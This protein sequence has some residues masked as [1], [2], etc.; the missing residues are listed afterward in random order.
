MKPPGVTSAQARLRCFL[1]QLASLAQALFFALG[2]GS[3]VAQATWPQPRVAYDMHSARINQIRATPDGTRVLSVSEDKTVRVWRLSDLAL[4]R[5]LRTPSEPG[6]EGA[7][8][9]LAT[10]P[11]SQSVIVGGWTGLAWSGQAH[12]YRFVLATGRMSVLPASFGSLIQALG[13]SPDG[14]WLA[15][16]LERGGLRVV[17]LRT[18]EAVAERADQEYADAVRFVEFGPEGTLATTSQD[19]CLRLYA[20]DGRRTF[21]NQYFAA[22]PPASGVVCTG[23]AMGGVRFSPDGQRLAWGQNERAEVVVMRLVDQ[24][25]ERVIGSADRQQRSLCC[26][27]FTADGSQLLYH[28]AFEGQGPTPLYRADLNATDRP[29]QRLDVGRQRFTNLL[30]LPGGDIVFS[31]DAPSLVR[32]SEEGKVQARVEPPN[33][34][35]RFDTARFR[36]SADGLRLALP[37]DGSSSA[38]WMFNPLAGP[39]GALKPLASVDAARLAPALRTGARL[40][41]Q[42]A[43]DEFSHLQPRS[44]NGHPLPLQPNQA[45]RSWA[46]HATLPVLAVGTQWSVL[47]AD[48]QARVLWQQFLPAPALHV[49]LSGD[50]RWVVAAVGDGTLRWYARE[51]GQEVLAAFVHQR[52]PEWVAWRPDGFYTASTLGDQFFGWQRN[53][54]ADREPDFLRAVQFERQLF[55]PDLVA[56][57]LR[58]GTVA[59]AAGGAEALARTL[60]AA[61]VPRVQLASVR[62]TTRGTL[63]LTVLVEGNGRAVREVGI[64]VDGLPAL[65]AAARAVQVAADGRAELRY[66]VPRLGPAGRVRVEAETAVSIGHDETQA[67][68][69]G[70]AAAPPPGRLWLVVVGSSVFDQLGPDSAL[71]GALNDATALARTL[72]ELPPGAHTGTELQLLHAGTARPP[73]K[74]NILAALAG[75]AQRVQPADTVLVF[76]ASHGMPDAGEYY[77]LVQDSTAD[78][79]T[80]VDAAARR[81]ERIAPG[82]AASLMSGTELVEAMRRL[83]GR[84]IVVLD[85]CYAGLAGTGADPFVLIKR[86][87]SAQLA[88][89]SAASGDELSLESAELGHG[90]FT[91]MLMKALRREIGP[92]SGPLTV[93]ALFDAVQPAVVAEVAR[94]RQAQTTPAARARIGP[95]TP[96]MTAIPALEQAVLAAQR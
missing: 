50:G 69:R 60:Q 10:A 51:S 15:V 84:R 52:L 14:R 39:S 87:A 67:D 61:G 5:T 63:A 25:I 36:L 73:T 8:R 9:A 24:V 34:D 74:A 12:L 27:I 94:L 26:P 30:P 76:V 44:I 28:G 47:L 85:T 55:R 89:V 86:S 29:P 23:S 78:D 59:T 70:V 11:D 79:A 53:R 4:L 83:P 96:V 1:W 82:G 92:A 88:V 38:D 42:A 43:L 54:G 91:Y 71:P 35:F 80:R 90:I 2:G 18:G 45:T 37:R 66:E 58:P 31:T 64:F 65:P 93:R 16:G 17:D 13:I 56:A 49:V 46:G 7:V 72:A 75:L 57:A 77:I 19:G 95:Q 41:L 21:R 68:Q 62:E 20:P 6:P 3:A 40:A 81:G 22:G 32:I 33:V 48:A